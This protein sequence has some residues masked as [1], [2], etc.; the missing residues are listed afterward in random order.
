MAHADLLDPEKDY[1]IIVP[2]NNEGVDEL[3]RNDIFKD[4]YISKNMQ[5]MIF[6]E[7]VYN[8]MENRLFDIINM[9]MDTLINMYEEEIIENEKL[10]QLLSVIDMLIR[11]S[12]DQK[13]L[14]FM[15][16]FRNLVQIAIDHK[17]VVG[18]CF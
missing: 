7:D 16:N 8:Y 11:N 5:Y 6:H 10:N 18:F 3:Y 9:K 15:G 2:T 12:D 4:N 17:S 13:A 14:S 1:L